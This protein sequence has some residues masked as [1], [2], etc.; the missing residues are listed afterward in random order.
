[1]LV[2]LPSPP[3]SLLSASSSLR[4]RASSQIRD[5]T[6]LIQ[7]RK[8][9]VRRGCRAEL[10]QD[11]PFAAAIG[12]CVLASLVSPIPTGKSEDG[13]GAMDS[14]DT[15]FAVMGIVSFIPYF[16]WLSWVFAWLDSGSQRYLI[17]SIVYLA[18]YLRTNLSL[19]PDESWLPIA[20][21]VFCILHVQLE[22]SIQNEDIKG[23]QF[24]YEI[25]QMLFGRT[26]KKENF[27]ETS[28]KFTKKTREEKDELPSAHEQTNK[29]HDWGGRSD[30]HQDG[31]SGANEDKRSD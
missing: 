20:S 15:R 10:A 18:P 27:F 19:S 4:S 29:S 1:M 24:F 23:F 31:T 12:A 7:S 9:P 28:Q 21:I 3:P 11:A 6:F 16:N 13:G 8:A 5:L 17:Y 14:T 2:S 22:A 25:R 26:K 30:E